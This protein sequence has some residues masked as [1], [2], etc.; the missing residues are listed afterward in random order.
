MS[1]HSLTD[2]EWNVIRR[3][4]P[5]ERA[6]K[7]GFV[8]VASAGHQCDSFGDAHRNSVARFA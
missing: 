4:L 8:E 6:G 7:A 3:F 2:L 1:L 5:A